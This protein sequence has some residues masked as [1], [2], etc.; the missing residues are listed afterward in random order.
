MV[1]TVGLAAH[2]RPPL[3][4][5]QDVIV[6]EQGSEAKQAAFQKAVEDAS[7]KLISETIGADALEKQAP[8]IKQV[9][10]RSEKY[11]LFI[12]GSNPEPVPEGSRIKVEMKISL[13][14]FEALLREYGLVQSTNRV[15]RIVPIVSWANES[16]T[17][18]NAW[19]VEAGSPLGGKIWGKFVGALSNRLK[20]RNI[21]LA[22][23][24]S[25]DRIPP[26][27]RKRQ[28]TREEQVALAKLFDA[29][30]I[31]YGDVRLIKETSGEKA[32][33]QIE[34]VDMRSQKALESTQTTLGTAKDTPES[35]AVK[36]ADNV[37]DQVKSA[38]ASGLMNLAAFKLIVHGDL[39]YQ[40]L[41]QLRKELLEQVLDIRA[42]KDRLYSQGEFVFEAESNR[43]LSEL[44]SQIRR[45]H[46]THL[47]VNAE[48]GS[49]SS[50]LLNV[51]AQ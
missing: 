7:T 23:G 12:K 17:T 9:L 13:D 10:S 40:K 8:R 51:S 27:L 41:D 33:L 50:L 5:T 34:L 11:I 36:V 18:R 46:F 21:H 19:W 20:A 1:M 44:A 4:L 2:A 31:V 3:E 29:S 47:K 38:Q 28:L 15:L 32:R 35:L 6:P 49:G 30:L 45:A 48:E 26:A 43:P 37:N 39:N 22:E 24:L 25:L 14:N 16:G 42:M